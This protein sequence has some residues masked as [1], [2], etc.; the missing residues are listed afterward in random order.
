VT[1]F[2]TLGLQGVIFD[3]DGLLFDTEVLYMDAW[4]RVGEIM[5]Y[6][7]TM[8]IAKKTIA[9]HSLESERMLQSF[10]GPAFS[11]AEAHR[12]LVEQVRPYLMK[13]GMP[14]KAGARDLLQL[15][16]D[17][18]IPIALGTSNGR[19]VA[20][21]YLMGSGL[22]EYFGAIVTGDDVEHK[23]PAPDIFLKAAAELGLAPERCIVL[24]DSPIGIEAAYRAGCLPA[25]VPD[26]L[27]PT[28]ETAGQV[29]RVFGSLVEVREFLFAE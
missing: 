10:F 5:G 12:L 15:L 22:I 25:M 20:L 9:R 16:R 6:P 28:E 3:M 7:I 2:E 18:G 24:E 14:E 13:H 1:Q 17:K 11:I 26:L 29:W 21:A 23:K 27:G 19:P 4:L 8:E